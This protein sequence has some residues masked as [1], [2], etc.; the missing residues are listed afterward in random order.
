VS[1]HIDKG[2]YTKQIDFALEEIADAGL[3]NTKHLGRI[4]L[5][6]TPGL[7]G[8]TKFDHQIRSNLKMR[9]FL[10]REAKIR[11]NV[12]ARAGEFHL[13]EAPTFLAALDASGAPGSMA[14]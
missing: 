13:H 8:F 2:V 4:S 9:G 3:C 12:P 7:D 1:K 11:E 5:L 6:K 14:S 10:W